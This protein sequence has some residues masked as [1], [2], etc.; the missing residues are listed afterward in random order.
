[1]LKISAKSEQLSP[2]G[3]KGLRSFNACLAWFFFRHST[4]LLTI[5]NCV[6]VEFFVPVGSQKAVPLV[7]MRK[8]IIQNY[9]QLKLYGQ[10][11]R[12]HVKQ[13]VATCVK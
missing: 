11:C 6:T 12:F 8:I 10:K 1:M 4:V 9:K 13:I 5:L 7:H 3:L 2:L